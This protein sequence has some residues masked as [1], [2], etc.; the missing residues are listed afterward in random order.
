MGAMNRSV[1]I[2]LSIFYLFFYS[3]VFLCQHC[4]YKRNGSGKNASHKNSVGSLMLVLTAQCIESI[5][6]IAPISFARRT[7][8]APIPASGSSP[9]PL[10]TDSAERSRFLRLLRPRR[11]GGCGRRRRR[12]AASSAGCAAGKPGASHA[13][14]A[15]AAGRRRPRS[16]SSPTSG[17]VVV[18]AP[19]LPLLLRRHR[20]Q[21]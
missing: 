6:I 9:R 20:L 5:F 3:Y 7:S 14:P 8:S 16:G 21:D 4:W 19:E 13:S 15:P 12:P 1:R 17:L 18:V 10:S 11:R 2:R